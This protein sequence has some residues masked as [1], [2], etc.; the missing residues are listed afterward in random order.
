MPCPFLHS[1][2]RKRC[3]FICQF[4][5]VFAAF[6]LSYF[7]CADRFIQRAVLDKETALTHYNRN[8]GLY[9]CAFKLAFHDADTDTDILARIL[10]DTSNTSDFL[11]LF[12]WQGERPPTF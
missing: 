6:I 10:A 12:L 2:L 8:L 3:K 7:T 1:I 5:Q 9:I 11:K 4:V